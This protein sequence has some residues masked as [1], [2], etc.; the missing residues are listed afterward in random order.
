[1]SATL[2]LMVVINCVIIQLD[3]ITVIV[4]LVTDLTLLMREF[5]MVLIMTDNRLFILL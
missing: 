2:H 5:A 3:L 4:A 1:M